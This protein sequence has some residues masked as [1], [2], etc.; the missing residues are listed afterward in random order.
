M[1]Y[2]I[3][4]FVEAQFNH[5]FLKASE[6]TPKKAEIYRW[7]LKHYKGK[8]STSNAEVISTHRLVQMPI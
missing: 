6:T 8:N 7:L 4:K 3:L 5:L 2:E 1:V